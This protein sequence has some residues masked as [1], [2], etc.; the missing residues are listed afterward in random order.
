MVNIFLLLVNTNFH[1]VNIFKF[2]L[3]LFLV[4][5]IL[6]FT[7]L[8]LSFFC[9]HIDASPLASSL[10]FLRKWQWETLHHKNSL[11]H[12]LCVDFQTF[13]SSHIYC[14]KRFFIWSYVN[15]IICIVTV[16]VTLGNFLNFFLCG[17]RQLL[18]NIARVSNTPNCVWYVFCRATSAIMTHTCAVSV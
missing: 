12:W 14:V 13:T 11:V 5:L 1:L 6:T 7:W 9:F 16:N 3:I 8:I 4:W 15:C 18:L 2:W 17:E 10:A